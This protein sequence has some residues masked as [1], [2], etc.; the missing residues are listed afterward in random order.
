MRFNGDTYEFIAVYV[1]DLFVVAKNPLDIISAIRVLFNLK[2]EGF[3]EYY[4]GGNIDRVK[5]DYTDSGETFQ[6]SAKTFIVGFAKRIEDLMGVF[7]HYTSP[8]DPTYKP[9]IDETPL[10]VGDDIGRYR[11][12]VG[13]L[14][15]VVTLCRYD[16]AYATNTLARYTSIPREGHLKAAHRVVGY[17]KHF[18]KGRIMYDTR[19][20]ELPETT[21][22]PNLCD[23]F[24]QYPDAEEYLPDD[25]PESVFKSINMTTFVDAD[26]ASY[27][28]TRRSVSGIIHFL[29][30]TPVMFYV[31]RQKTVET[32]SYGSEA[33]SAR[34]ATEQITAIRYRL[35]MMG[36]P[37]NTNSILLGDNS[38]V[39]VI[40]LK[41]VLDIILNELIS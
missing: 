40:K 35:R 28:T 5:V 10:L 4:L 26:H 33:I 16:I 27:V 18:S 29:E 39:E 23:W 37:V 41:D 14:Q 3:P 19:P 32:S 13:S 11:M 20:L 31:G 17:L 21:I 25:M 24:Q 9:E 38:S 1:D 7:R 34:I 36:V 15:W 22:V 30:S 12:L 6:V 2:G 8:M